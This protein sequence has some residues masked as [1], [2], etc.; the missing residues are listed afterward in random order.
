[1]KALIHYGGILPM[2]ACCGEKHVEFLTIDHI[3][4]DGA[5]HRKQIK[6]TSIYGWLERN[7]FPE[8]FQVLCRN[9]NWAKCFGNCPHDIMSNKN[10][11]VSAMIDKNKQGVYKKYPTIL[12]NDLY[13][14]ARDLGVL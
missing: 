5:K 11:V 12:T 14:L 6:G 3:K 10:D 7:D 2:C 8:G 1:M 9:C 13:Q 4:N